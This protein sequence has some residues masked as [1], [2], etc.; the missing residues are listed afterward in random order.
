[1]TH[2]YFRFLEVNEKF[3][4]ANIDEK[5]HQSIRKQGIDTN[6]VKIIKKAPFYHE[7]STSIS[8]ETKE[9]IS[10]VLKKTAKKPPQM[11]DSL[12]KKLY[13]NLQEDIERLE[14]YLQRDLSIWK[15]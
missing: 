7:I 9:F 15:K 3:V 4:P 14:D 10:K 12:K 2:L 8:D 11:S 1:M 13:E 5:R 6:L